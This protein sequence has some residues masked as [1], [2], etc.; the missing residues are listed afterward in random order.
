MNL[1]HKNIHGENGSI[2]KVVQIKLK[3]E[4][5][6]DF[7]YWQAQSYEK[8]L[9]ALEQIRSEYHN[10]DQQG[11]QRVYSIVKRA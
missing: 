7:A 6:S 3:S 10:G 2:E 4:R 5:A 11:F 1:N 9:A 8:R